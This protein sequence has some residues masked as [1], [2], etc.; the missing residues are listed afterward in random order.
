[1]L[2]GIRV[3]FALIS[4]FSFSHSVISRTYALGLLCA[5][6]YDRNN[7]SQL[8]ALHHPL[9]EHCVRLRS[10]ACARQPEKG[11]TSIHCIG[12]YAAPS[13]R[14]L[15]LLFLPKKKVRFQAARAAKAAY[16]SH[17]AVIVIIVVVVVDQ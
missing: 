12:R 6:T 16:L 4:F 8:I 3:E 1:M 10:V 9:T 14:T 17:G 15:C 7:R 11:I 13:H 2:S 5:S